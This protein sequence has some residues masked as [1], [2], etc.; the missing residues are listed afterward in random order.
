[1][2]A[3]ARPSRGA[4]GRDL[5]S[6]RTR[7]ARRDSRA[8]GAAARGRL[9]TVWRGAAGDPQRF[10]GVRATAARA[11]RS[12]S[13]SRSRRRCTPG[14]LGAWNTRSRGE[15]PSP[16]VLGR[17]ASLHWK[18]DGATVQGWLLA[19]PPVGR[20][21]VAPDG[22]ARPR[23]PSPR[24]STPSWPTRWTRRPPVQGYYV[25]LPNPRGS[26]GQGEAFTQ[27]NVKDF[28]HGDL[29][30]ILAGVDAVVRDR[31]R[32]PERVGHHRLE[33]RRLHDDVGG[34][35]DA[36][37]RGRRRG[38][39]HRELAELLRAEPDR[40]VDDPVLRRVGVRRS[41]R[42]TRESSPIEFIKHAK[43]PT[44]VL[45]GERDSEVPDAAGL[46]VLARAEDARRP[47]QLVD[48]PERGPRDPRPSTSATSSSERVKWFDKY[49]KPVMAPGLLSGPLRG[50]TDM[51]GEVVTGLSFPRNISRLEH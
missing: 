51:R 32:R 17:G 9:A 25:F 48:L 4:V 11:R 1:M 38:R 10:L 40:P 39:G 37:L 30:D 20:G 34:H 36:A 31:A 16:A 5:S 35:A 42:Y 19:P 15:R 46:R 26:Y 22:G 8:V 47:D 41:R 21:R 33:L 3:S 7:T 6:P 49:L 12:S 29:R 14:P 44:L 50:P 23:R 24:T 45:H 28:G 13:P 27:A 2:H 43:T 18:S